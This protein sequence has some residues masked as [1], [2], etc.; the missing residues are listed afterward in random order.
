MKKV[1]LVQKSLQPTGGANG[2]AAWILETLKQDHSLSVLTWTPLDVAS[3]NRFYGTSLNPSE[4]SVHRL[5]PIFR[6]LID[7]I[8]LPLDFL[9]TSLLL[10]HCKKIKD[11]YD[12]IITANNEADLGC[13]GIQYIHCPR[14]YWPSLEADLPGWLLSPGLISVYRRV[15]MRLSGFSFERMKQNLTLVNSHWTG[16]KVRACYGIT[17]TTLYPPV[18]GDFPD[19]PWEDREN[20]FVCIGRITPEKELDKVIDALALVRSQ[21]WNTHLHIIGSPDHPG[22]Y[23]RIRERVHQNSSWIYLDNNLSRHELLRLVSTHRYGIHGMTE[24]HFGLAVAEMVR[25][26]CLVFLPNGGGQVEIVSESQECFYTTASE[27]AASIVRVMRDPDLQTRLRENLKSARAQF[28]TEEFGRRLRELVN[29][30]RK[31]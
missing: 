20:G 10:R 17:A 31:A 2:V 25:G 11:V 19:V 14:P 15:C 21:G 22:Y 5:H 29:E 3:I 4:F 12:I 26:G 18:A 8:P 9:K 27:A 6:W 1:L 16:S 7:P 30:F 28:S 24:E 23:D 13:R